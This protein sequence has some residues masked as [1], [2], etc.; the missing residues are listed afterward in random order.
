[1]D[2]HYYLIAQLPM[3]FFDR[4][5]SIGTAQFLAEAEKW[6]SPLEYALL[7]R[8]DAAQTEIRAGDPASLRR[9]KQFE[10][11]LRSELALWRRTRGT[12]QEHRPAGIPLAWLREGTPLDVEVRLLRYRWDFLDEEEREHNFD[13]ELLVLYHLK[14]QLLERLRRFDAEAGLAVFKKLCE[15]EA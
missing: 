9:F 14:L 8:V 12:E 4:E 11:R 10:H 15:A 2:K 1:M 6:L 13:L 5:P 7:A 3:L